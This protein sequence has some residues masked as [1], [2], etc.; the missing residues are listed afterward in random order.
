[1]PRFFRNHSLGS[2]CARLTRLVRGVGFGKTFS[3]V[4]SN[5]D[6]QHVKTFD[7]R[8]HIKTSGY[9]S[10]ASTSF[11]QAR[12]ADATIYG[13]VNGWALRRLLRDLALPKKLHFV[14]LGCGLGRACILAGEY[15]F[16][17]VTGVELAPEL[18]AMARKNIADCRPPGGS[19]S[20][21]TVRQMDAMEFCAQT[22]DDV[23]FMYRPFTWTF[24]NSI[25]KQLAERAAALNKTMTI[26]YS[27]RMLHADSF[28][29][30]FDGNPDFRKV[31]E[32]GTFGQAFFIYECGVKIPKATAATSNATRT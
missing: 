11:A 22:D 27:E 14:D 7:R 1:M 3:I 17:K 4:V 32:T 8:Y 19:L 9:I 6:D 13:P 18:C 28:V 26:I 10:L 30:A 29:K 15:G 5:V 20:P 31:R 24:L 2:A 25:L 12:L 21:I 23:F 16:E